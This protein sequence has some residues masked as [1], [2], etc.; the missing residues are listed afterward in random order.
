M[1]LNGN[2][3]NEEVNMPRYAVFAAE[4]I[5][6][7]NDGIQTKFI[8]KVPRR[9]DAVTE[10]VNESLELMH[11][12]ALI[13]EALR[14]QADELYPEDAQDP[15]YYNFIMDEVY[16]DNV[17]IYVHRLNPKFTR[18]TSSEEPDKIIADMDYQEFVSLYC[19]KQ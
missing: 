15:S 16:R 2:M 18:N 9:C 8:T 13:E 3:E 7:G 6:K 14:E 4:H 19:F 17:L 12:Y 5:H 1:V 10:A 11:S